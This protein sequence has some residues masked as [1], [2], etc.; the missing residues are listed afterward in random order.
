MVQGAKLEDSLA[1][2]PGGHLVPPEPPHDHGL[3]AAL[4]HGPLRPEILKTWGSAQW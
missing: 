2:R 1:Q 3:Q 4:S